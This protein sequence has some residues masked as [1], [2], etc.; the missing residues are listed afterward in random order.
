MRRLHALLAAAGL[1]LSPAV[2][3]DPQKPSSQPDSTTETFEWSTVRSNIRLGVMVIGLTP[4]L[5]THY[6]ATPD[7]GVLVGKVEPG[8]AAAKAGIQ[9]GDVITEVKGAAIGAATDVIAA[10]SSAQ[11]GD[12]VTVSVLRDKRP[13]TLTAKV[14][15]RSA[16][17]LLDMPFP[18]WFDDMLRP[19]RTPDRPGATPRTDSTST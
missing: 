14:A 2:A 12:S 15:Q 10:L 17:S 6:G 8:S 11:Q 19:F 9:V 13:L 16:T 4:E 18:R 5:R 1:A 7:R 3:A